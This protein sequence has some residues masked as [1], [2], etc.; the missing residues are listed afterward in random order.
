MQEDFEKGRE[1]QI[2]RPFFRILRNKALDKFI[3][4]H[5]VEE[6]RSYYW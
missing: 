4:S 6:A 5:I 2:S 1:S 3:F